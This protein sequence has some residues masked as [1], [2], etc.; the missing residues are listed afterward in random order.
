M[1]PLPPNAL[2]PSAEDA[3]AAWR[4][5]ILANREQIERLREDERRADFYARRAPLFQPGALESVEV[6]YLASL[7][8]PGDQLLDVGAGG[9][10]FAIPLAGH[11]ASVAAV[12]P[13]AAMREALTTAA[14]EHG[15]SN[16]VIHDQ[17]WPAPAGAEL[18]SG[19]V[20]LV[21][22]V[23]YDVDALG[24]FLD[25]LES[26]TRRT[27]AVILGNRAPS[28]AHEPAWT[29]LHGEPLQRLPALREFIAVLAARERR[30]DVRTFDTRGD[31]GSMPADEAHAVARRLYWV[32]EGSAKDRRL[33]ELLRA[34]FAAGDGMIALPPR[35][36]FTAVVSWSPA[37]A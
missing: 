28:T 31:A 18:A 9:G 7:A 16:I 26:Q 23:L 20:S 6:P 1:S 10:R 4:D 32:A 36:N 8:Q 3:L 34:H 15:V 24:A 37:G 35:L 33:G 14:S 2:R 19:D 22:H 12:E 29:E 11:F 17:R 21:S 13:S 30:F 25:A 5:L 27:C